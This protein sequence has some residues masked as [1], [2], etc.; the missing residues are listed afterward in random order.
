MNI[1]RILEQNKCDAKKYSTFAKKIN[2]ILK[3][4]INHKETNL[5]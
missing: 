4:N 5:L 1:S 2:T 3:S